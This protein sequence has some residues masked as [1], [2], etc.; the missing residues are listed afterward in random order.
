MSAAQIAKLA[1]HP[2]IVA[3]KDSGGNTEKLAVI[4]DLL[5]PDF[6]LL[7]GSAGFLLPAMSVGAVGGVCAL[8]NVAPAPLLEIMEHYHKGR[9]AEALA[10]QA[11]M[12][13]PNVAVTSKYG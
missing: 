3:L 4:R 11:K 1:E 8:A 2:N 5:G 9:H 7:A 12:A 13:A 10:L 6:Q